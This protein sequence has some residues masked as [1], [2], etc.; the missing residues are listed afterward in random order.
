MLRGPAR[1]DR[2]LLAAET[3]SAH[4]QLCARVCGQDLCQFNMLDAAQLARLFE[5]LDL[6]PHEH[7]LDLG[8]GVGRLTEHLAA[9]TGARATGVDFAVATMA[10]ARERSLAKSARVRFEVRDL[11]QDPLPAREFDAV[12]AIDSLYFIDDL[13]AAV[14]DLAR[15]LRPGGRM[16]LFYS[17][18]AHQAGAEILQP[19]QTWLAR[20]LRAASLS[21][22]VDD[23]TQNERRLWRQIETT[24]GELRSA[25]FA[26]GQR[27]LYRARRFES[28]KMSRMAAAGRLARYLYLVRAG[29]VSDEYQA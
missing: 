23:F 17:Q 11:N 25:F 21:Y 14:R 28:R 13:Y 20:A 18:I 12:I 16:A 24:L 26:E 27:G 7:L 1:F 3:S 9:R 10:R 19:D 8:C 29:G 2:L 4:G 15:A 22:E 6:Q 5:V